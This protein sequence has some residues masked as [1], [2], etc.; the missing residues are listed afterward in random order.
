MRRLER[1]RGAAIA[2]TP[3]LVLTVPAGQKFE[4]VTFSGHSAQTHPNVWY[5]LGFDGTNLLWFDAIDQTTGQAVVV[6]N[7]NALVLY[8]GDSLYIEG[9]GLGVLDW[10]L[11][12]VQVSPA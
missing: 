4:V 6:G 7:Y 11:A 9:G 1:L 2:N 12:Y 8:A 5:L 3:V 10:V